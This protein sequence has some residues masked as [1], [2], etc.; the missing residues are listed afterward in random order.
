MVFDGSLHFL[1]FGGSG[2]QWNRG[3]GDWGM[4]G[5]GI[6]GSGDGGMG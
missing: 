4:V 5:L 6:G 2:D 3:S 1:G